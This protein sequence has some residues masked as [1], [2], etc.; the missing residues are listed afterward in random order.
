MLENKTLKKEAVY[1]QLRTR[2]AKGEFA[3]EEKLP[4]EAKFCRELGV[5]RVTL[6][7]ALEKLERE[8]LIERRHPGGTVVTRSKRRRI[9]VVT[10]GALEHWNIAFYLLPGIKNRCRELN[11]EIQLC[12]KDLLPESIPE[13]ERYLG[14][15]LIDSTYF[16]HEP[17]LKILRSYPFPTVLLYGY[18]QDADV[19][20]F[21]SIHTDMTEAWKDGLR[22]LR[23]FGHRR[24]AFLAHPWKYS[25]LRYG[26]DAAGLDAIYAE[27]GIPE[28]SKF[29]R[30]IREPKECRNIIRGLM[31]L[32]VPPT[33]IYCPSDAY[34]VE[35]YAALKELH[36]AIPNQVAVMNYLGAERAV[37]LHPE[38]S[39]V[40]PHQE[41]GARLAVDFLF[42]RDNRENNTQKTRLVVPHDVVAHESTNAFYSIVK[43]HREEKTMNE[44]KFTL[45]ELLVVIAI[46]AILASMLLPTLQKARDRGQS[47]KCISNQ[48]QL[49]IGLLSYIDDNRGYLPMT[50]DTLDSTFNGCATPNNPAWYCKLARYVNCAMQNFY[51]IGPAGTENISNAKFNQPPV[52][53]CPGANPTSL[54]L[55]NIIQYAPPNLVALDSR[56]AVNNGIKGGK[57]ERMRNPGNTIALLESPMKHYMNPFYINAADN[58]S[59]GLVIRHGAGANH[60][61][62][63]GH[64]AYRSKA[65]LKAQDDDFANSPLNPWR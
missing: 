27:F 62:F 4:P 51:R 12:Q 9:L 5:A 34:A 41:L 31:N 43:S 35:V 44:R 65:A 36:L 28:S 63:A 24:I 45:I 11:V 56:V 46:I 54:Q 18:P 40:D 58:S 64:V 55:Q 33:A 52:F 1:H 19:T 49:G 23:R 7:A 15:I 42:H 8:G 26:F 16:G 14:V 6:R 37:L 61:F 29:V 17:E 32:P 60:L 21:A 2:I 50:Q 20:G 59:G 25:P 10:S 57:I 39:F 3:F 30:I 47:I 53:S 38:L 22:H 13:P 48:K